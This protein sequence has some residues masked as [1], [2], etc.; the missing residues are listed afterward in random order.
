LSKK[1]SWTVR[2]EDGVKRE[3]RVELTHRSIKWQFKRKDEETWDYDSKPTS[4]DW[5]QLV[6]ILK[7]RQGRGK[8]GNFLQSVERARREAGA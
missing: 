2:C 4:H 1:T 5:D 3:T 7:R 6:D 8:G